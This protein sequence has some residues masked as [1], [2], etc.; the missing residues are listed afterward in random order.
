MKKKSILSICIVYSCILFLVLNCNTIKYEDIDV[1]FIINAYLAIMALIITITVYQ[2]TF[3]LPSINE[4]KFDEITIGT[5][6]EYIY[7]SNYYSIV[8]TILLIIPIV[9][10]KYFLNVQVLMICESIEL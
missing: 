10:Y 8:A 9:I 7:W 3:L 6:S 1:E 2:F 5:L 4:D